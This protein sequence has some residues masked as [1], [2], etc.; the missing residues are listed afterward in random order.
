MKNRLAITMG[1]PFGIG[2]EISIKF[3]DTLYKIEEKNFF[4][5]L[6]GSKSVIEYYLKKYKIDLEIELIEDIYKIENLNNKNGV[7]PLLNID[8]E[9]N[10]EDIGKDS[11]L[12][13][14]YSIKYLNQA[15]KL[16]NYEII[17]GI[18]TAPISK[19]SIN[20]AGYKYS[21]HTTYFAEKTKTKGFAMILK[22]EKVIVLLNTT[23]LSLNDAI[24]K[25][26]K[27]NIIDKIKLAEIAKKELGLNG[28]IAV[29]GLNPHNGENGLFGDEE[30]K[31]IAPAVKEMQE[32]GIDVEGPI[33]PDTLFVKMLKSEYV[34]S[35]VMYHDQG[36]IP[37]KLESFG[38]AV[39]I[40]IGL[41][42]VRTSVDHGTAFDIAG[43]NMADESSLRK[44][45]ST[46]INI[47][48]NKKNDLLNFVEVEYI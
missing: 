26:K 44:A 10:K 7:L 38:S 28:K 6:I 45:V 22:G 2:P 29:A 12:G 41:P 18:V 27:D 39:N 34:I 5:F 47:I 3:F 14:E 32:Q 43:K 36:L 21:G 46:A 20:L 25:V 35:V 31:E 11:K 33:V 42:F 16:C 17:D 48:K 19:N 37:V 8:F 1:D 23:H 30:I 4:V 13:G 24:K 15:I 40:T 9:F